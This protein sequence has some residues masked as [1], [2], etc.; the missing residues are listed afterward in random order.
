[1]LDQLLE[2]GSISGSR[3]AKSAC[4]T[5]AGIARAEALASKYLKT[6]RR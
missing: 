3:K 4:L 5:E 6:D 2:E 1:V